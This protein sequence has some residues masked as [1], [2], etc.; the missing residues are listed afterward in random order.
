MIPAMHRS[1]SPCSSPTGFHPTAAVARPLSKI[2]A[3]SSS[4]EHAPPFD[5]P[6]DIDLDIDIL[7]RLNFGARIGAHRIAQRL[8][9]TPLAAGCVIRRELRMTRLAGGVAGDWL[10]LNDE[11]LR[12]AVQIND[13]D[14]VRR[15][16]V[17]LLSHAGR[18]AIS[19][20]SATLFDVN[21]L[22]A[23]AS[24]MACEAWQARGVSCDRSQRGMIWSSDSDASSILSPVI[25]QAGWRM[26]RVAMIH[27][28]LRID[29]RH[30]PLLHWLVIEGPRP[31][32][33]AV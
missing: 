17:V 18:R 22:L 3:M 14:G 28:A 12:A 4:H 19:A 20:A 16:L 13:H 1:D 31:V 29:G 27:T 24:D 25:D 15:V 7:A 26:T 10:N 5:Q 6:S 30:D 2:S 9:T 8:T 32:S 21:Q 33:S 23:E 11:S